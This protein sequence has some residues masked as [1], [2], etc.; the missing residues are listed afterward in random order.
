MVNFLN[1][2]KNATSLNLNVAKWG[3][4]ESPAKLFNTL[5]SRRVD[6]LITTPGKIE[7]LSKLTNIQ[8]P[9]RFF[10][11]VEYCVVDEADTLMD[12]SWF[13][14]TT[15]VIQRFARLKDL[16]MCSATIPREFEKSLKK[17]VQGGKVHHPYCDAA[18]SQDS[19]TN[20]CEDY[21]CTAG[22]IPRLED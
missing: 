22:S 14:D 7:G 2:Q 8:R 19:K 18:D 15:A 20:F 17:G 12:D 13:L 9:F 6:V 11:H 4:G 21:R 1:F 3:A 5:E 16:V 10:N